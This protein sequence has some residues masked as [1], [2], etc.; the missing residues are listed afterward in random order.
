MIYRGLIFSFVTILFCLLCTGFG[1]T[2]GDMDD[3]DRTGIYENPKGDG[4]EILFL[5]DEEPPLMPYPNDIATKE[6]K[7]TVTG[8]RIN[9][10][11]E[12]ETDL[13]RALRRNLRELDGFGLN[14]SVTVS[15]DSEINLGT[16]NND[17]VFIVNIKKGSKRF[18]EFHQIDFDNDFYPVK[19]EHPESFFPNDKNADRD[20]ILFAEGNRHKYYEDETN[21]LLLRTLTPFEQSSEYAVVLTRKIRDFNDEPIRP[22]AYFKYNTMPTQLEQADRAINLVKKE[23]GISS[24]NIA[25]VWSF[26]TMTI[27]N[28]IETVR[29]G[30]YGEGPFARLADEFPPKITEIHK[31]GTETDGQDDPYVLG[32]SFFE[33]L[34]A[35][36]MPLIPEADG[37]PLDEMINMTNVDYLVSGTYTTPDFLATDDRYFHWDWQKGEAQYDREEVPF[38][39]SVPKPT[40]ENGYAQPPYP[41]VIFQHA[42]VRSRLDS[43]TLANAMAKYGMATIGIDAA[44]HGPETYLWAIYA[45]LNGVIPPPKGLTTV[46]VNL[47]AKLLIKMMYPS[48]DLSGLSSQELADILFAEDTF[49]GAA[50]HGRSIDEEGDGV[51]ESGNTFYS[52]DIFRTV[53]I[54]RQTLID[55]FLVTKIFLHMG[56]DW[57]GNGKLNREEGDFNLDGVLDIGGPDLPIYFVGMSLGSILGAPFLAM[58]PNIKTAVLNVPGGV[59]TDIL[60]RTQIPNVNAKIRM[61][62]IGPIVAGRKLADGKTALTFNKYPVEDAFATIETHPK[63]RA[64]LTNYDS[65]VTEWTRIDENGHFA[66]NIAADK[67]DWMQFRVVD[68]QGNILEELEWEQ[69]FRGLGV[70]RNTPVARAFI[71]SAQWAVD[72]TDPINYAPFFG[73]YP[74]P[75]NE[76]KNV[77]MQMCMPDTAVPTSAGIAM[78][79][80][81]GIMELDRQIKLKKLGIFDF[82]Y[83]YFAQANLPL[84]SRSGMS[85]RLHPAYNHEYM[86]APRN[87]PN[88]VMYSFAAKEQAAIYLAT[89]GE[90]IEDNLLILV[91]PEYYVEGY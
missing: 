83:T 74:R 31:F 79:R 2:R 45:V 4:P 77:L 22:P 88:S 26:T 82:G 44:E 78:A 66:V 23:K 61:D 41:M 39:I 56:T 87:E 64:V 5:P 20:N 33:K 18:G 38:F 53:S 85:W 58:E 3:E 57:D 51:L 86:L 71:E 47:I 36:I 11:K 65:E 91:P 16:V 69:K 63:A 80:S 81:A 37:L 68:D 59:L 6:D 17:S 15:F 62:L 67:G 50:L 42:N 34:F 72:Q 84:H 8:R 30:L 28:P 55:L 10:G 7:S 90:W 46:A 49:L 12:G 25:F 70:D 89:Q 9:V 73:M 13:N 21:T 76:P 29:Q 52:A 60:Q 32:G 40:E 24:R 35:L 43:I 27:T 48:K 75:G 14:Q 19:L 1:C 54:S